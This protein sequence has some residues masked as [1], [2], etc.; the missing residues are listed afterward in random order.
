[1]GADW[2]CTLVHVLG[3]VL[4]SCWGRAERWLSCYPAMHIAVLCCRLED[5]PPGCGGGWMTC[6]WV[7][8]FGADPRVDPDRVAT[9]GLPFADG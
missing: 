3:A 8:G 6:Y 4:G 1:M 2:L 5:C 7:R 9:R